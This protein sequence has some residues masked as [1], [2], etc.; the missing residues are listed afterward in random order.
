MY[1]D[2]WKF[3]KDFNRITN[4]D[5]F[6]D[7]VTKEAGGLAG[8]DFGN[9]AKATTTVAAVFKAI[10]YF[11]SEGEMNDVFAEMPA[12]LKEFIKKSI[13]GKQLIL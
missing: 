11:V 10:N 12:A 2:G 7:E 5:D 6:L 3:N 9:N 13:G 8:Y 4:I 1:V